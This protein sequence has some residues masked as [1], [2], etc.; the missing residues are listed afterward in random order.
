MLEESVEQTG[1]FILK[2][3][4]AEFSL[5]SLVDSL[6]LFTVSADGTWFSSG[7]HEKD[8]F[9]SSLS[10]LSHSPEKPERSLT[11]GRSQSQ[12]VEDL[13]LGSRRYSS[14]SY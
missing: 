5:V 12:D 9:F 1:S 8:R 14:P 7:L 10:L 13:K 4:V 11:S 3:G 6:R 2:R